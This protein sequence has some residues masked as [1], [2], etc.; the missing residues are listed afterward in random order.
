M[1]QYLTISCWTL[2]TGRLLKGIFWIYQKSRYSHILTFFNLILPHSSSWWTKSKS[3]TPAITEDSKYE[4]SPLQIPASTFS[5]PPFTMT[6]CLSG[7]TPVRA[8]SWALNTMG[9]SSV[10][11]STASNFSFPHFTFTKIFKEKNKRKIKT[12]KIVTAKLFSTTQIA[13][14]LQKEN[15]CVL[16]LIK[17]H[18]KA[19]CVFFLHSQMPWTHITHPKS[20][21][22]QTSYFAS[23]VLRKDVWF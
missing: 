4:S 18:Q 1:F 17:L 11:S 16:Q 9:G 13:D 19:L 15:V 14:S 3:H 21:E 10:F 22:T 5:V 2:I 12:Q 20:T 6:F 7:W 23:S 8:K